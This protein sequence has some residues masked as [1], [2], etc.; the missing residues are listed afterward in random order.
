MNNLQV[1]EEETAVEVRKW[2]HIMEVEARRAL[3]H[4][5]MEESKDGL[6]NWTLVCWGN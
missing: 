5:S 4:C 2:M 6:V 1:K 3:N